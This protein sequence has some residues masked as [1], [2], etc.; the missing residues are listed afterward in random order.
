M[1]DQSHLL[2]SRR[3]LPLF[4]TQFFGAFNDNAFKNAFLIWFTFDM[5]HTVSV[6]APMM[7]TIAAG[8]FI[9]PFFLFSATAG[10]IADKFEKSWITR[11]IKLIEIMLMIACG[12]GFYLENIYGLLVVLFLMGMQSTFFGPIKYSLLPEHLHEDELIGGNGLIEGGTFL[13]ILLGT[14]FG[15]LVIRTEYGV[16]LLALFVVGF[17]V[18]GYIASRFIPTAPIGDAGLKVS[19]NIAKQTWKIMGFAREE[20][21][22]WLSIIGISWFWLVGAT[23]LTQ[24]PTYTKHVIGG[25]EHIVTLFL[26]LFSIGVGVGSVRCNKLLKGEINGRLVPY[27]SLGI[28]LAIFAFTIASHSYSFPGE[29]I[30]LMAFLASGPAAW[31]VVVSLLALAVCAGVYIVPLYAIMQHRSNDVYLARII[32]ANNVLNALFMVVASI[33]AVGLFALDFTV[34]EVLLTTG[35]VNLGVFFIVR[36]VVRRRLHNA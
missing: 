35:I 11:K 20:R 19:F 12:I 31:M 9:L 33:V 21:T 30:G 22:V 15:G 1:Q 17:A 4:I 8:L 7:V 24:F 36:G 2:Q 10:Q 32:A 27:G 23:F 25:N 29:T 6:S 18:L 26:T 34:V 16:P 28:S 3:F 5:A 14:I 13:A